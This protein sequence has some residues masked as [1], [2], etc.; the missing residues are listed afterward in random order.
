MSEPEYYSEN[1]KHLEFQLTEVKACLVWQARVFQFYGSPRDTY[2]LDWNVFIVPR[3]VV[4]STLEAVAFFDLWQSSESEEEAL[5]IHKL[6]EDIRSP[7]EDSN[8][9]FYYSEGIIKVQLYL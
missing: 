4:S 5:F 6:F 9:S 8:G 1:S 2:R 7:S 3:I